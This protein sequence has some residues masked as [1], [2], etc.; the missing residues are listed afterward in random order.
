MIQLIKYLVVGLANTLIG[1]GI[2]FG[3]MYLLGLGP[4]VSNIIGY[5]L[6]LVVSYVLHRKVTFRSTQSRQAEAL[7]FLAVF[8]IAY[9]LNLLVLMLLIDHWQVHQGWSQ[10][11]AGVVYVGA[12]F[13]MQKFY[14]FK[15]AKATSLP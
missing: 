1:Y 8:G 12:S 2:I 9:A 15:V 4:V 3:C 13:L 10:V 11:I 14:V 7:R 6:G 5:G